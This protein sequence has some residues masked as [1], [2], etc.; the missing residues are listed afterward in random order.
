MSKRSASGALAPSAKEL[1]TSGV[2]EGLASLL[3]PHWKEEVARWIEQDM[4]K[5]DV[6]GFVVGDSAHHAMLLGKGEG[7]L[8]GVPFATFV[9]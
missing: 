3:P 2:P 1:R 5:W 8:A 6:G 4:P 9:F 7:V